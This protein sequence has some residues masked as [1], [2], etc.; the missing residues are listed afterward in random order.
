ML[1]C[2]PMSEPR[3]TGVS[4]RLLLKYAGAAPFAVGCARPSEPVKAAPA[5]TL[6]VPREQAGAQLR[7]QLAQLEREIGG[8]LG[9]AALNTATG[10]R[11]EAR[12]DERFAMCSTFKLTLVSAVLARVDAGQEQ[13]ERRIAFGE[14]ALLE[15]AP[16][17]REH[18]AEGGMSVDALCAAAITRSDNTAA[19]LLLETVGGP[20]GLTAY[21]R[22]LGDSVTRLDRNEPLLNTALPDDP[23]DTTTP[24]AMLATMNAILVGNALSAASRTRLCDWLVATTTG[25]NRLR[26]GFNTKFRAGDKTGTG[27]NGATNDLAVVWPSGSPAGNGPVLIA[28]YTMGSSASTEQIGAGLSRAARLIMTEFGLG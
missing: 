16:V 11:V 24:R 19:N 20:P 26:A 18:L 28:A 4:R 14:S 2:A 3:S 21:F 5:Q 8:R 12:A 10:A 15:Y 27:E 1:T 23:R 17:T 25:L 9:L 13:L 6:T 7:L 22:S